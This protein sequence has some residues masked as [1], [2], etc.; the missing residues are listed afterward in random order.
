MVKIFLS[1]FPL[2]S[3]SCLI[4]SKV[5]SAP[6]RGPPESSR[7]LGGSDLEDVDLTVLKFNRR[8]PVLSTLTFEYA[9]KSSN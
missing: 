3:A 1:W 9:N 4:T 8:Q 7:F 6:E 5:R 2:A